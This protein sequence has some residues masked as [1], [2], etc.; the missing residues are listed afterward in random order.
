MEQLILVLIP[1]PL[2]VFWLWMFRDMMNN[3]YLSNREK[4][5]WMLKFILLNVVAAGLYYVIEYK[6]RNL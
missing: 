5:D 6:N 3:E 4:N 2:M 1:L